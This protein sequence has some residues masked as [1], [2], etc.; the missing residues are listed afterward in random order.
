MWRRHAGILRRVIW[1]GWLL[2]GSS[3][4]SA[5]D[6]LFN[7]VDWLDNNGGYT[8][9]M[10][11]WGE[12]TVQFSSGDAGLFT[13][14][15]SSFVGYVN[16]VTTVPGG[17]SNNWAVANDPVIFNNLGEFDNSLPET[18][19]FDLGVPSG[20]NRV[21]TLEYGLTVDSAP[22]G[23]V[24]SGPMTASSVGVSRVLFGGSIG[25]LD[26]QRFSG[27]TGQRAPGPAYDF[28]GAQAGET[29]VNKVSIG[30]GRTN[31]PPISVDPNGCVPEAA[32]RSI[33][34]L[35][36]SLTNSIQ[37]IYDTLKGSNYMNSSLG[38]NGSGTDGFSY[39][40]GKT[41]YT[42]QM[43]LPISTVIGITNFSQVITAISNGADVEI[44]IVW[45]VF[46]N[47]AGQTVTN[48]APGVTGTNNCGHLAMVTDLITVFSNGVASAYKI[49]WVEAAQSAGSTNHFRC[50]YFDTNGIIIV[51][52]NG[53]SEQQVPKRTSSNCRLSSFYVETTNQTTN[54]SFSL[55]GGGKY[56]DAS[57]QASVV[58]LS[59]D[60]T[61]AEDARGALSSFGNAV[62]GGLTTFNFLTRT[63]IISQSFSLITGMDLGGGNFTVSGQ[64]VATVNGTLTNI[65]F[66]AG[67]LDGI[68]T[69]NIFNADTDAVLV[70]G[71][72]EAGRADL[73]LTMTAG[74]GS[75]VNSPPG[76]SILNLGGNLMITYSGTLLS[77]TNVAG[78]YAPVT[79]ASSPFAVAPS[80][81]GVFYR[82]SNP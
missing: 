18:L 8:I 66:T 15:G 1:C 25:V 21:T 72:G 10:S 39:L 26:G 42:S 58:R 23:S 38:T 82:S 44:N 75:D 56:L 68:A 67:E 35:L 12:V 51:T 11:D 81:V 45:Q 24:P 3:Q 43:G 19:Y 76:I 63:E 48:G 40:H 14:A 74:G 78:P 28:R 53:D 9:A 64:G 30:I 61:A 65:K 7:Q 57:G 71:T 16:I 27:D 73:Q 79:G 33:K 5:V 20:S 4:V 2:A 80:P 31:L 13:Q 60:G 46:T 59:L 55:L 32:A 6:I 22:L 50:F 36:P 37:A 34:Y 54:V 69:L 70:G 17:S 62:G 41:N 47:S 52:T 29:A 77:S 49:C